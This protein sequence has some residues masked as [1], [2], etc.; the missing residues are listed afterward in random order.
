MREFKCYDCNHA[1][2]L[3]HGQ[4]GRGTEQTCPKC[5]SRNVH[6]IGEI[7]R[8]GWGGRSGQG[9]R[10]RGLQDLGSAKSNSDDS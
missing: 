6:R 5:G 7:R 8:W 9:R 3:S 10:F 1:W 4:G 2:Q